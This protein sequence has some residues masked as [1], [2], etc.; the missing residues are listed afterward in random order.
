MELVGTANQIPNKRYRCVFRDSSF[1]GFNGFTKIDISWLR[2]H[3]LYKGF[4]LHYKVSYQ[5]Y[6]KNP[7][8]FFQTQG[9]VKYLDFRVKNERKLLIRNVKRV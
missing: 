5:I 7:I 2:F 9:K 8:M 4:K 6:Q 1:L 3:F